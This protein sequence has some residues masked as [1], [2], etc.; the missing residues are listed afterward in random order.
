MA[1]EH[2]NKQVSA[3]QKELDQTRYRADEDRK[4]LVGTHDRCIFDEEAGKYDWVTD[5]A[6]VLGILFRN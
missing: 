5:A 1:F 6:Y 3:L 4:S 2:A